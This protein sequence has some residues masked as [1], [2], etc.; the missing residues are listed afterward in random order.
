MR[1]P[2]TRTSRGFGGIAVALCAAGSSYY[3]H[4]TRGVATVGPGRAQAL[5]NQ[6]LIPRGRTWS[7]RG[8]HQPTV[9][10]GVRCLLLL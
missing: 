10:P 1:R 4:W 7:P 5:P 3:L 9:L 6:R 8:G 2:V